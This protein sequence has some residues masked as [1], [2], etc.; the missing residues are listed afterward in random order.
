MTKGPTHFPPQKT[1][2]VWV[3]SLECMKVPKAFFTPHSMHTLFNIIS[4]GKIHTEATSNMQQVIRDVTYRS[5]ITMWTVHTG[6]AA[7]SLLKLS[8][9]DIQCVKSN[10]SAMSPSNIYH[11]SLW[12]GFVCTGLLYHPMNHLVCSTSR[13]IVIKLLKNSKILRSCEI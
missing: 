7:I 8:L 12:K 9:S 3:H 10:F 11:L 5:S 13:S 1:H 4:L 2:S 6:T